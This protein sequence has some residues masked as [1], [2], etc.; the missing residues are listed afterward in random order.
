VVGLGAAA[1]PSGANSERSA[2]YVNIHYLAAMIGLAIVVLSFGVQISRI[3]GNYAVI[4]EILGEV[5]RIRAAAER[6]AAKEGFGEP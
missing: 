6:K 4:E 2:S 5:Q 1:D 3:A